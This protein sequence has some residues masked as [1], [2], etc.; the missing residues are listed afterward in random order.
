[1]K[2][3]VGSTTKSHG[4]VLNDN[5]V[6]N[7]I[8]LVELCVG[9]YESF[10]RENFTN[11][12]K[13]VIAVFSYIKIVTIHR[14]SDFENVRP[15]TVVPCRGKRH[16]VSLLRQRYYYISRNT[17]AVTRTTDWSFVRQTFIVSAPDW[18]HIIILNKILRINAS[19]FPSFRLGNTTCSHAHR[20]EVKSRAD[21][22]ALEFEI[23]FQH[24]N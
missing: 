1:M 9:K 6:V 18:M 10:G 24:F 13:I 23:V 4:Y 7:K 22:A 21:T 5:F 8:K 19:F 2:R 20:P 3:I 11:N 12:W 14:N 15:I 16:F 17:I